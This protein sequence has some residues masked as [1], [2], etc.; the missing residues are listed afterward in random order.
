MAI[1]AWVSS[2]SF[3]EAGTVRSQA[4]RRTVSWPLPHAR[5]RDP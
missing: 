1:I 5:E 3:M 4:L 2:V